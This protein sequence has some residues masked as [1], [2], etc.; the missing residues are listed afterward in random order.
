[1]RSL[2]IGKR[3]IL[4][5]VVLILIT[6][7]LGALAVLSM[8]RTA[9]EA[10]QL[11]DLKVPQVRTAND[12]ERSAH[13]TLYQMSRYGDTE[14][15]NYLQQGMQFLEDTK[16]H[17][18]EAQALGARSDLLADLKASAERGE[19]RIK[20]YEKF[21]LETVVKTGC[22]QQNRRDLVTA[23][24]AF[25]DDCEA[26]LVDMNEKLNAEIQAKAPADTVLD[27]LQKISLMN[28]VME[29]GNAVRLAAWRSQAERDFQQLRDAQINFATIKADLNELRK[30]TNNTIHLMQVQNCQAT[31]D[32]FQRG[33]ND[34]LANWQAREEVNS[35]RLATGMALLGAAQDS[36]VDGL[37]DTTDAAGRAAKLLSSA[38]IVVV[39]G[40]SF[41]ILAG[42]AMA[43]L[44]SR[45]ANKVLS[46]VARALDDASKQVVVSASQVSST[47]M[48]AA[49]GASEQAG[50]L[51]TTGASLEEMSNMTRRNA[52]DAQKAHDLANQ[53][54]N[55]A[56][57]GAEDIQ[58]MSAAMQTI[59]ASSADIAKIIKTID[60][61][62]FQ[63]N[64]LALN[65]AVEAARAGAAGAGFAVVA[66]EV[67]NLAHRSA[68]AAKETAAKIEGAIAKTAQG[69]E[70]SGKVAEALS[71]ITTKVREVDELV[72]AVASGSSE[73]SNG[74]TQIN[75][76]VSQM[77]KVTQ[78]NAASAE[79]GAAVAQ[80]LTAQAARMKEAV[81]ELLQ[82]VGGKNGEGTE[83]GGNFARHA[84]MARPVLHPRQVESSQAVF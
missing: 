77:D 42:V 55:A 33:M 58:M 73:Q 32:S 35:N 37:A 17:I 39:A 29:S 24:Q 5:F 63:T 23:T 84:A 70:I 10:K 67:R 64:I 20:S 19:A 34:L 53:A 69:V 80:E 48:S 28:E 49:T 54:R 4:G 78:S 47:S 71:D 50:S 27:H 22:I 83:A 61:I 15:T 36:A 51:E 56:N 9:T 31:A 30:D 6:A 12:V 57:K 82:L 2:T 14:Q 79:E 66:D 7:V 8:H 41:I 38:N 52:A 76:A 11:V 75:A 3:I 13:L 74:I 60:E 21:V 59:K 81:S 72:A 16:K 62:A 65:A 25:M 46:R 43:F 44:I 45:S 26:Y 40:L 68:S 18:A 1:M